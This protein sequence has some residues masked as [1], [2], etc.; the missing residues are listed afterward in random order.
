MLHVSYIYK[1][2][3]NLN[4]KNGVSH[5]PKGC[6]CINGNENSYFKTGLFYARNIKRGLIPFENE[7][8]MTSLQGVA[9]KGL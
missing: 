5:L 1:R 8:A 6:V 4:L 9:K 7:Q 3:F 2:V